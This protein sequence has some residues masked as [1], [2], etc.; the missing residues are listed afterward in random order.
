MGAF[1]K[2]PPG[3]KR[4]QTLS[5]D[6][7]SSCEQHL[8]Q[9]S[10]LQCLSTRLSQAS[11]VVPGGTAVLRASRWGRSSKSAPRPFFQ[12]SSFFSAELV[13]L[14]IHLNAISTCI[15][16]LHLP[17]RTPPPPPRAVTCIEIHQHLPRALHRGHSQL[18]RDITRGEH[19]LCHIK[20]VPG[21]QQQSGESSA[22]SQLQQPCPTSLL[23]LPNAIVHV[24]HPAVVAQQQGDSGGAHLVWQHP[25]SLG[26]A[27]G[28]QS[29]RD[30]L[31]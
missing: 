7:D 24:L 30:R 14:H 21:G 31:P 25:S 13:L 20:C 26:Q 18:L 17:C 15:T 29:R 16:A 12:P 2:Q 22:F 23:L 3:S 10:A 1:Q 6:V 27:L 9:S 11:D 28:T 8:V 4:G 5:L 19:T